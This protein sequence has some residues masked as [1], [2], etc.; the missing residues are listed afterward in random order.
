MLANQIQ[1]EWEQI[2]VTK[3]WKLFLEEIYKRR[4]LAQ[5]ECETRE[6]VRKSQGEIIAFDWILGRRELPALGERIVSKLR[7]QSEIKETR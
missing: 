2:Q 6:D 7:E 3:F 4:E 1:T 5:R